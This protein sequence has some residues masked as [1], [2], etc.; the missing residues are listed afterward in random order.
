MKKK[1]FV[2][3]EITFFRSIF[4][5]NSPI[6]FFLK[7]TPVRLLKKLGQSAKRSARVPGQGGRGRQR[8][9]QWQPS[10]K[11]RFSECQGFVEDRGQIWL[12]QQTAKKQSR[13]I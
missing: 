5:E 3:V 6:N 8:Q 12:S 13:K 1:S 2:L 9:W 10:R 4:C 11:S 7:K